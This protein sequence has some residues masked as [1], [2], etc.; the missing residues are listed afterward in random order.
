MQG[1]D[2]LTLEH[3]VDGLQSVVEVRGGGHSG[4]GGTQPGQIVFTQQQLQQL[5]LQQHLDPTA[6]FTLTLHAPHTVSVYVKLLL[7]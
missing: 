5:Q 7:V 1:S 3:I 6:G 4:A 2:R